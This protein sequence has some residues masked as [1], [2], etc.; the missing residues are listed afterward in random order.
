MTNPRKNALYITKP[1]HKEKSKDGVQFATKQHFTFI[2]LRTPK[3]NLPEVDL[4]FSNHFANIIQLLWEE[5][6]EL[7]VIPWNNLRKIHKP[8]SHNTPIPEAKV[9]I[10]I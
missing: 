9:G 4:E 5:D 7:I 8:L 6:K 10:S 3:L 1:L 2:Q